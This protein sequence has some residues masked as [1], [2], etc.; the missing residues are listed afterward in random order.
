MET[1]KVALACFVGG[2]LGAATAWYFSPNFWWLGLLAGFTGGYLG[3]EFREVVKAFM[4]ATEI[5]GGSVWLV[6]SEGT[7]MAKEWVCE[8]HP[9]LY[10]G[11]PIAFC[12]TF[13]VVRFMGIPWQNANDLLDLVTVHVFVYGVTFVG[14]LFFAYLVLVELA[15][16]GGVYVPMLGLGGSKPLSYSEGYSSVGQG[17]WRVVKCMV[18]TVV[19]LPMI[20]VRFV[21][22][23]F[24]LVHSDK[25]LLCGVDGML[26]G[27]ASYGWLISPQMSVAEVVIMVISGGLLGA[28][29]G[30]LQWEIV[31]KRVLKVE[32]AA[33]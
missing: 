25:R 19:M 11:A 33:V 26:G 27:V 9:F 24:R 21:W 2:I 15:E 16:L 5:A 6:V 8:P 18:V 22:R 12:L 10:L 13:L 29:F 23:F 32:K 31:S 30:V 3:Y 14:L 17:L 1:R 28:L 7:V 4:E 20:L